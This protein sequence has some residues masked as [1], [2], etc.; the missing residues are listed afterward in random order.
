MSLWTKEGEYMATNGIASTINSRLRMTGLASGLDIDGMITKLMSAEKAQGDKLIQ[1]MTILQW[2]RDD[3]RS[4]TSVLQGFA[5]DSFDV[6]KPST[7]MRSTAA[8]TSFQTTYNGASTSPYFSITPGS[9]ASPGTYTVSDITLA[10]IAKAT[11]GTLA[12]A[13]DGAHI[14]NADVTT[15]STANDNNKISVTF[16]GNT[17]N[18]ILNDNPVDIT[19]LQTDM[20]TKLNAAFGNGKITV[21]LTTDGTGGQLSFSSSGTDTFSIGY[22]YNTGSSELLGPNLSTGIT[23]TDQNNKFKLT[24]GT[25][26]QNISL[27]TG[28]YADSN[29]IAA[30][31]QNKIDAILAFSGKVRVLNQN[32]TLT[33]KAIQSTGSAT[34]ALSTAD[35]S[36]GAVVDASNQNMDIT[37]NGVTKTITLSMQTYTKSELLSAVQS[38]IDSAF[39]A[40]VGMVSMNGNNLRFESI[41]SATTLATAKT[42]N[43]GL[44][45]TGLTNLNLSNKTDMKSY[46]F[47][48]KSTFNTPLN[49]AGVA[50]DI[51]FTINGKAFSF[52]ST[53]TSLND[54]VANVNA[55]TTANVTMKYDELNNKMTV[56]SKQMGVA[57]KVQITDTTGNLMAVMGLNGANSI[58]ADS[59][60]TFNDGSGTQVITRSSND[61]V[62]SGLAFS[63]KSNMTGATSVS[64]ASDPSATVDLIKGFVAKYNDVLNKINA[65]LSEKKESG[66]APLTDAQKEAMNDTDIANWEAKA[67]AGSLNNDSILNSIVNNMRNALYAPVTGVTATLSSIGITTGSYSDKGKLIIDETKLKAAI[68]AN[69]DEVTKLFTNTSQYSYNEGLSDSTKRTTRYNESGLAQRLF[70][71][72]QDN[73]RTTRDSKGQK[74]TLLEKAGVIGDMSEFQSVMYKQIS[75]YS[76]IINNFNNKLVDKESAYYTKFSAMETALQKMNSQGQ[77]LSSQFGGG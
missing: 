26:T 11:G 51:Q 71:V 19:A 18:I 33:L 6:L 21:G 66:Y 67:K 2:K 15:I 64:V 31:I 72:I 8:F 50:G 58:G 27:T 57:S 56:E 23:L 60:L 13:V 16:N 62:I 49:A 22:A 43:G 54:I 40:N 17:Q 3:Y 20:Q 55:D 25:T 34:G 10:K 36:S 42:E 35:V 48:I 12:G 63:L 5:S 73:S 7:N 69:P 4:M 1:K 61:F 9:G 39:G 74:G 32:N 29:A 53:T 41:D 68:T 59:S 77:W 30:E 75:D 47:D 65:K 24:V 38:Q 44:A 14:L 45:L 37:L 46:L 52:N 76:T 28:V 70:D